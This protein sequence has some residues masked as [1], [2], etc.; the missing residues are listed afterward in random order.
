MESLDTSKSASFNLCFASSIFFCHFF[1]S[2]HLA[3]SSAFFTIFDSFSS[4]Y[5]FSAV[6]ITLSFSWR[7]ATWLLNSSLSSSPSSLLPLLALLPALSS[8]TLI[9]IADF[10]SNSSLKRLASASAFFS[11]SLAALVLFLNRSA[12]P[13]SSVILVCRLFVS[14]IISIMAEGCRYFG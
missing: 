14:L 8:L 1:L 13:S 6:F 7:T 12:R 2:S 4:S 10:F 3:T 9:K 11:A 5:G